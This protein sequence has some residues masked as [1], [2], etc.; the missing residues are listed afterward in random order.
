MMELRHIRYFMALA[1][2]L[3]F[4]R[5]AEQ[6]HLSQPALSAQVK[7]LEQHLGV[8]LFDRTTRMVRLTQA[9]RVFQDDARKLLASATHAEQRAKRAD[10]G[11]VGSLRIGVISAAATAS[12]ADVLRRF[13]QKF[14]GVQLSLF[15]LTSTEQLH[16]LRVG[17]LDAGLL[18]PPVGFPELDYKSIEESTQILALPANHRLA[19]K[20]RIEWKDFDGEGLVMIHPSRQ[21]RYYETFLTACTQAGAKPFP[22][23]YAHDIQTKLWLISAG[24]GIAPTS[25]AFAERKR[26]G[27]TFRPLPPGLPLVQT[28]L[29]WRRGD[30]SPALT[31]FLGCFKTVQPEA[32]GNDQVAF[33]DFQNHIPC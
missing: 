29:V 4:R 32:N 11:L 3:N 7:A 33:P 15:D 9:G 8:K 27:L 22:A 12:L 1:E 14:P 26:P 31:Q 19:R 30:D 6:L 28:I 20:R 25:V 10:Q 24:F 18:R 17:E 13:H 5:A 21:H 2:T 23:Q 16:Q